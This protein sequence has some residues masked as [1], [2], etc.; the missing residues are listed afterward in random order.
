[1]R[2][3]RPG[4][5]HRGGRRLAGW[6]H[7]R[8]PAGL[9]DHRRHPTADRPGAHRQLTA[10]T[11][12]PHAFR[13]AAGRAEPARGRRARPRSGRHPHPAAAVLPPGVDVAVADRPHAEGRRRP[14]HGRDRQRLLRARV[15]DGAAGQPGQ[16]P[17]PGNRGDLLD[18]AAGRDRGPAAGGPARAL[19]DLQR[20]VHDLLRRPDQPHR[21]DQ[22]GDPAHPGAAPD[23]PRRRRG[24]G[25]AGPDAADRGAPACPR[26]R[27]GRTGVAGRPGPR[28]V[29]PRPDR[30]GRRP[31]HLGPGPGTGGCVPAAGGHRRRAL[32]GA[33]RRG[34]RLGRGARPVPAP[35]QHRAE[36]DGHREPRAGGGDGARA[37]RGA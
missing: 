28:P 25:A 23:P 26:R 21:P 37:G 4:G 31:R 13:V 30:R 15:D 11:R 6:G 35:R 29:G 3:R 2:G 14:R 16:A 32:R 1:V 7:A 8:Q 12:G 18:A 22:R 19:P 17:Y 20:G 34:G 24:G 5:A 33:E 10:A 9:A 36:P 27:L